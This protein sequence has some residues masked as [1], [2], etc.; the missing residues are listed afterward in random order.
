[1]GKT[2]VNVKRRDNEDINSLLKR[3]KRRV[4]KSAHIK[5][6][7]DRKYYLKPSVVKR[8]QTN[9]VKHKRKIDR[10]LESK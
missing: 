6:L 10:L 8:A 9:K 4:E 3:F 7:T 1:M 5:E 2:L